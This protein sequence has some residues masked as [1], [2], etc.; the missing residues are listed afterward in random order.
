MRPLIPWLLAAT[1][2]TSCTL[3]TPTNEP[4]DA[5]GSE[6]CTTTVVPLKEL[7]IVDSS[8]VTSPAA[9]NGNGANGGNLSFNHAMTVLAGGTDPATFT[10]A[11][12]NNWATSQQ[13][14]AFTVPATPN[15]GLQ[16][17]L[18]DNG[19]WPRLADGR[20]DMTRAPFRL[21][22]VANRMDLASSQK[23]NGEGRLVFGGVNP[24][25]AGLPMTLVLEYNL[26]TSLTKAQWASRWHELGALP[27]GSQF[28][29]ALS[30]LATEF[31]RDSDLSQLR[32]NEVFLTNSWVLREFHLD[33]TAHALR[34]STTA[35]TPDV[36]LITSQKLIDWANANQT[37]ILNDTHIVPEQFLGGRSALAFPGGPTFNFAGTQWL[38][39]DN[40][41][42]LVDA[43]V[44]RA[45]GSR[46]CNGCHQSDVPDGKQ[47]IDTF[48][49]ISPTRSVT[50][51]D[52]TDRLSSF[53]LQAELPRR[54]SN[55]S[56]LISCC[57]PESDSALCLRVGN[58]CGTVS[59]NDNCG[60]LR[61]VSCGTCA[62]PQ[63][64]G[65]SGVA[66]VCGGNGSQD[67]TE[68]GTVSATGTSCNS[69]TEGP[70]KA[71]D[72]LMTSQSFTKWCV[73]SAPTTSVPISTMYDFSGTTAFTITGY[74]ITTG[75]DA[76][77]RDPKNWTFQGCQGT[78]S[79]SSDAG[80]VTLDTRSNQFAGAGRVQT[81]TFSLT[82]GTAFQQYRLRVTA[83]NGSSSTFQIAELQL[84]G[85]AAATTCKPTVT[86][87]T[88]A[89][90]DSTAV[91][92]GKLYKCIAQAAGVNGEPTGCGTSGV[93][94][95]TIP[96]TNSA[97]GTTAWQ[98][99]ENC[100]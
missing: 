34:T 2:L 30:Q 14:G 32:V 63:T 4:V 21:L 77:S 33:L 56:S 23:P 18:H 57:T 79:V 85:S 86:S 98:F 49:Q 16:S 42:P 65:G 20:L 35:Q 72:N 62:A 52:G 22:A 15:A 17:L 89:K 75:N 5:I 25:G 71:Y 87:T 81:S 68:G 96:P 28:N 7:M 31:S 9:A 50:S 67:R 88:L 90:C 74:A 48:Y 97:W 66:N 38:M 47:N 44:R 29:E 45:F 40:G 8:V 73:T 43:N 64:C 61:T 92:E 10:E 36:S 51:G 46:T 6:L 27:F 19:F 11:F 80:W 76:P 95:S 83:N 55:L 84:F 24:G 39:S 1:A 53:I 58:D 91:F 12:L 93:F 78:C 26:P 41:T 82:N 100:P 70:N 3:D 54:S 94:C 59:A 99:L 69:S 37:A 60:T 13:V